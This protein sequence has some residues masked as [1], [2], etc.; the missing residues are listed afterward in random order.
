MPM[1]KLNWKCVCG[2]GVHLM[3]LGHLGHVGHLV[4]FTPQLATTSVVR[5]RRDSM[6]TYMMFCQW[7]QFTEVPSNYT[8]DFMMILN[9]NITN[10][11][12][13]SVDQMFE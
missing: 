3:H 4:H 6:T 2:K 13:S 9:G 1:M 12:W 8:W 10:E 5:R 11:Q 7:F